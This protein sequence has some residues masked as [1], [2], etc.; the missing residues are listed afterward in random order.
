MKS[1]VAMKPSEV[2]KIDKIQNSLDLMISEV[3][4]KDIKIQ[5]LNLKK[6]LSLTKKPCSGKKSW[7]GLR[8]S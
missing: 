3:S 8:L 6:L 2:V 4:R 5:E 1:E 7:K